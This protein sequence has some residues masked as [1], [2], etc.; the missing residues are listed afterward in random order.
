MAA[1]A[2]SPTLT[3]IQTLCVGYNRIGDEG[4]EALVSSPYSQSIR[5]IT[6]HWNPVTRRSMER[7]DEAK[8]PHDLS[9]RDWRPP[10]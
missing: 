9:E 7:L 6:M 10:S 4:I 2:R 3:N 1:L 5:A 8:I